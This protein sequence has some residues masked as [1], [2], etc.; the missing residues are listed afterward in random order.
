MSLKFCLDISIREDKYKHKRY[1]I[2]DPFRFLQKTDV[3]TL[4]NKDFI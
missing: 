1:R 3:Y 2:S 4:G